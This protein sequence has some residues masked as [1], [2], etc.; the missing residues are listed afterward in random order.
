MGELANLLRQ[1][2]DK[3]FKPALQVLCDPGIPSRKHL[4]PILSSLLSELQVKN[5]R[6]PRSFRLTSL[7]ETMNISGLCPMTGRMLSFTMQPFLQTKGHKG[8]LLPQTG[9]LQMLECT[10]LSWH[11]AQVQ[12]WMQG[13]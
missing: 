1:P 2:E 12:Y 3:E 7:M 8:S 13:V 10:G 6:E 9:A 5:V 11:L 4:P